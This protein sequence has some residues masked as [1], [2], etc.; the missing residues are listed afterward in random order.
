MTVA[1]LGFLTA[2]AAGTVHAYRLSAEYA[3]RAESFC[4]VGAPTD[5]PL[6]VALPLIVLSSGGALVAGVLVIRFR[7][8]E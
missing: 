5:M 7:N 6:E 4:G 8:S 2:A 3:R 1:A